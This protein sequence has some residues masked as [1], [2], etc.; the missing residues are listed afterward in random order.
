LLRN[1]FKELPLLIVFILFGR[2]LLSN[3]LV[4]KDETIRKEVGLCVPA[5]IAF[6]KAI[7][8]S[9]SIPHAKK[10]DTDAD[11]TFKQTSI[12]REPVDCSNLPTN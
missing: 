3:H 9:S 1:L 5:F 7:K 2:A 8:S 6:C 4:L 10:N 11:K 12:I